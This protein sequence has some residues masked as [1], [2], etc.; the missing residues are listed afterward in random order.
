MA[1]TPMHF[2][3]K[4]MFDMDFC[5]IETLKLGVIPLDIGEH[6]DYTS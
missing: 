6:P 4:A 2:L 1:S 5:V 3:H